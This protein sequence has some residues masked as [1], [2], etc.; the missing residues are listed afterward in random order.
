MA[1]RKDQVQLQ[2]DFI[3][4]ESRALARTL[5]T[6]KEYNNQIAESSR[7]IK[8]YQSD[9]EKVGA[10]ET[11]RAALLSKIA[12][13]EQKVAGNLS[14][15]VEEGK[16]V[17][18]ID[19]S[20]LTGGQLV[21]RAKQLEQVM[22]H[23]PESAPGFRELQ[24]ELTRVNGKI[25]ELRQTARGIQDDGLKGGGQGGIIGSVIG[26]IA[27]FAAV[28]GGIIAT[29]QGLFNFVRAAIAD[30]DA[31]AKADAAL[32]SRIESTAGAAGR[33]FEQLKEQAEELQKVTLFG[34][35]QVQKG[36]ELLLTFT[37]IRGEIL[38]R[39]VPAMLDLST[40]FGQDVS[41]SAVQL[42][43]ALNDPI[44]GV[45]ALRRVGVT[46]SED[47][48]KMIRSL[49]ETGDVAGAQTV[50]LEELERQV[51]G[52]ARAAAEAG[53]GPYQLLQNR[54]GEVKES[55]GELISA[56][57]QRLRPALEAV[58]TF[59][60]GVT[61]SLL[62]GKSA[63]GEYSGAINFA[64]GVLKVIWGILNAVYQA[65][66]F[67][68]EI[69]SA[70]ATKIA[71]FV[72]AAQRIPVIKQY[73]D[74]ILAPL[75]LIYDAIT[76]L[77]AT[78]LGVV[79]AVKQG[80]EN[81]GAVFQ[82]L[83]LRAQ[84][85]AKELDLSLSIRQDT[86]DRL[87]R[88]LGDLRVRQA[89]IQAGKSVGEAYT[90]AR[91]AAI[92]KAGSGTATTAG[93]SFPTGGLT[94]GG[95][96]DAEEAK[97]RDQVLE[98]ELK[99]VEAAALRR[100]VI[101][102]NSRLKDEISET[103]YQN[104]LI[105]L[106]KQKL[107]EQL[108]VYQK[109]K[110]EETVA[111]LKV[112]NELLR[113]EAETRRPGPVAPIAALGTRAQGQITSQDDGTERRLDVADVGKDALLTALRDKFQAAVITEQ[114]YELQ[115]LEIQRLGLAQEIE[116]LKSATQPQVEEVRKR[117]EA[118]AKV[119]E[120]IAAK[121]IENEQRLQELKNAAQQ[122]GLAAASDLFQ[123]GADLLSQDE[124]RKGKHASAIK[125]LE[126]AGVNV[127]LYAEIQAIW[128]NAQ[129]APIA[130]LLGPIA[131]NVLAAVQT[132]L[133]AARAGIAIGK[134]TATKFA[135]GTLMDFAKARFGY[136]GGKPHSQGGTKG[137]FEDGTAI[138]VEKDEAF[139]V[140]NKKNAPLLR[141]LSK[142]NSLGG[143]GV[144]FFKKGGVWPRFDFG[145]LP[146]VN[147]TPSSIV[148]VAT[149][150]AP[151]LPNL[152]AFVSAIGMFGQIVAAFP[153]EVKSRIVTTE[154]N[155][156]QEELARIQAEAAL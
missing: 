64:V 17:E 32:K 19:L 87:T 13:E 61:D 93:K 66:K 125:A 38:D 101:L 43:K 42:G 123:V 128:A 154:I 73:L 122:Q 69:Y 59:L 10:D 116:I 129:K 148:Q 21:E 77:P 3:T 153:T 25:A 33:S 147:T 103:A 94:V 156:S 108:A 20:R 102:E 12:A 133:A 29:L 74:F 51:G 35:D 4:D 90:E 117:E 71:E 60:E 46:F 99:A 39:T 70:V 11:K 144:P 76:N 141:F 27:G 120:E 145:G 57:L 119:E 75:R 138:E 97:R 49:V 2:V 83:V 140:V 131:G 63:T 107:Q 115:K 9:L 78:W 31:G 18:K 65:L 24:G 85:F 8:K 15:I 114:E 98:N 132:A 58:I 52:A 48:Q 79:A 22:K 84:I 126:I 110:Q 55:I 1:V 40:V 16:K 67:Q 155:A 62:S 111:A 34:D 82:A 152:D 118:K 5:L 149:P 41:A 121:R 23:I 124:K 105:E 134:I 44:T 56:G 150:P 143:H 142:V 112:Q 151:G 130:K 91:N 45:T 95:V 81:L 80:A 92:A 137:V 72:S 47:Q 37:N 104:R 7:L 88:E 26:R 139:A 6:T 28:I 136:F 54:L 127:N 135:H 106:K 53:L 109:F 68:F 14:K 36:Q 100:E 30:F 89:A 96:S 86:K 146:T 50:I 113:L